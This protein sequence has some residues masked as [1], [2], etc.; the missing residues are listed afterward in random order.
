MAVAKFFADED[1]RRASGNIPRMCNRLDNGGES[2]LSFPDLVVPQ[3]EKW[4]YRD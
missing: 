2:E 3:E 4:L 1:N